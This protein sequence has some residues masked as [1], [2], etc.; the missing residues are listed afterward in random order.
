M[1]RLTVDL[2]EP[3]SRWLATLAYTHD[4]PK[5]QLVRACLWLLRSDDDLREQVLKRAGG[6]PEPRR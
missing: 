1:P 6:T 4:V 3:T 2:D 5:T